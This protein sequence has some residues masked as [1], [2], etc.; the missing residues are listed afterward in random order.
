[1]EGIG[2]RGI[3]FVMNVVGLGRTVEFGGQAEIDVVVVPLALPKRW[4]SAHTAYTRAR[5]FRG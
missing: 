2:R 1:V 5:M 4:G 3:H